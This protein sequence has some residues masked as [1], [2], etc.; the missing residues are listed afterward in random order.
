MHKKT[1][2]NGRKE[3]GRERGKPFVHVSCLPSLDK[4]KNRLFRYL[5]RQM[6]YR[7][8]ILALH[9]LSPHFKYPGITS[10]LVQSQLFLCGD[11]GDMMWSIQMLTALASSLILINYDQLN[12]SKY[13]ASSLLIYLMINWISTIFCKNKRFDGQIGTLLGPHSGLDPVKIY[14]DLIRIR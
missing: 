8:R 10:N 1:N 6:C 11:N 14:K 5:R 4:N 3:E 7:E 12:L 13:L 2:N 9:A